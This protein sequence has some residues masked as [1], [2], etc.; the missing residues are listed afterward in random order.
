MTENTN[1]TSTSTLKPIANEAIA[2]A[3]Q[4]IAQAQGDVG[5]ARRAFADALVW[6]QR[7]DPTFRPEFV[8]EQP[9]ALVD[10]ETAQEW[11]DRAE[12]IKA[13]LDEV[14]NQ[15]DEERK[16]FNSLKAERDNAL[17]ELNDLSR[18]HGL[19]VGRH[20]AQ[21]AKLDNLCR[22]H[23]LLIGQYGDLSAKAREIA[24]ER[25]EALRTLQQTTTALADEQDRAASLER[26][27]AALGSVT[28]TTVEV[29]KVG[30]APAVDELKARREARRETRKTALKAGGATTIT[31][32]DEPEAQPVKVDRAAEV[33]VD[34]AGDDGAT[35]T[36]TVPE[37]IVAKVAAEIA[38]PQIDGVPVPADLAH[39]ITAPTMLRWAMNKRG[40]L[41]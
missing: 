14:R 25:D 3:C 30:E 1:N 36:A 27:I 23:A 8:A 4:L 5:K 38:G 37:A 20:G 29:A 21:I 16:L 28:V 12:R 9:A 31:L 39:L 24:A 22:E 35:I 41:R 40:L 34:L 2:L 32:D 15:R 19:L 6:M 17:H 26:Q 18:E 10:G 11:K 13:T 7:V 33:I